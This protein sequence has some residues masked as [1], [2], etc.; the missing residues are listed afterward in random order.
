MNVIPH[1]KRAA[2]FFIRASIIPDRVAAIKFYVN[3][4]EFL[5]A[6][7]IM[8]AHKLGEGSNLALCQRSLYAIFGIMSIKLSHFFGGLDVFQ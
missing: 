5:D 8:M 1:W 3:S 7:R 4:A 2:Q 6:T